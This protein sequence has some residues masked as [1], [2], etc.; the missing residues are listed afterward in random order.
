ME[1]WVG[2]LPVVAWEV[3]K[4]EEEVIVVATVDK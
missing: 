3:E 1:V 4:E 2:L